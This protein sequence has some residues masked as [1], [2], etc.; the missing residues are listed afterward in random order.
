MFDLI[1]KGGN[2]VTTGDTFVA[3]IGIIDGKISCISS[4]IVDSATEIIDVSGKYLV[5]GGIDVHT[6]LDMPFG[7]TVASDDFETGTIAA[8]CGGTTSIIDFAIQPKGASLAETTD[9]WHKKADGKSVIDYGFHIAITDMNEKILKEIPEAISNGYSSFKLFMTYDGLRVTDDTLLKALTVTK[10][11]GGLICVHAENYYVIDYLIKKYKAEG[12][13][14]PIYHAWSRPNV[15]ESEAVNRALCMANMVKAPIYIVHLSCQESLE[16]IQEARLKGQTV[17]AETCPQYLLLDEN[18]Y[19]EPNFQGAKYVMSPPLREKYSQQPLWQGLEK[20]VLQAVATD[21]CPFF[22]EG[23]KEL[24]REFFGLIPNGA[25]GIET[26][27]M[28]L[29]GEGV[30]KGK[31]SINKFV[32]ITASNPAKIFGLYPHKGTISIGADAD[33]VVFDPAIEKTISHEM[34]HEN[35]DYTP[36]EGIRVKGFPTMTISGGSIIAENGV[37]KGQNR[38]GKFIKRSAPM[39]I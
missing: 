9:L 17:M 33:I 1:L 4:K 23:Q 2:I 10:E 39:V 7:G 12:K 34:L 3:D 14:E 15:A 31:I 5:P 37:F 8:A 30:S 13:I 38:K 27:M 29:F 22:F 18:R 16:I 11:H 26:R 32:E 6:H 28:L 35:V 20:G 24:G 36:Y 19:L 21:H 25:P